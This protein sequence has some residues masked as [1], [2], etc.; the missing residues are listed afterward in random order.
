VTIKVLIADD[1]ELV[2]SGFRMV[3][4]ARD[5][6]DVIGEANNGV[7]A[8]AMTVDL[9]PDVVLMDIRMPEL[10]GIEA[11]RQ[12][13][14]STSPARVV[15]LTTYDADEYVF[16]A[17]Q[18]GATGFLLKDVRPTALV[19]AVRA[20]AAG[21]SLLAPAVTRRMIEQFTLT[22]PE[23]QLDVSLEGLTEREVE[24]LRLV[25]KALNNTEIAAELFVSEATVKTHVSAILRKLGMRDRVQAAVFAYE[26]GLV[27]PGGA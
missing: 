26:A 9:A 2:R 7:E 18:A 13:V 24:V 1:Q 23:S 16:S 22:P 27:R 4:D 20:A 3:L 15:V 10:D 21:D 6:L 5:D 14:A 8:V 17:L 12:I 11:T 25:A 19:D